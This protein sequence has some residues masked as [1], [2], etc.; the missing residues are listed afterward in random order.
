MQSLASVH[1]RLKGVDPRPLSRPE[2]C[3]LITDLERLRSRVDERLMA[4]KAA[5]DSL[6]DAGADSS[7]V[8]RS[9]GRRSERQ[10]K[11]DSVTARGLAEM[12]ALA[13]SLAEGRLNVE[14][15]AIVADAAEQLTPKIATELIGA[16]ES[17]PADLFARRA[18]EFVG[19]H[20]TAAQAEKQHRRQR[21][22]RAAWHK[23]HGDGTVEIHGR[24]DKKTGEDVLAAWKLRTDRLWH[25]D[26][27]RDGTPDQA[28]T[29]TQRRAD[30][31][32]GLITDPAPMGGPI[33]PRF[34]IHLVWN[35][36]E[37]HA[38]WLDGSV[39]P[40]SVLEEIGPQADVIAHIFDGDGQPLWQGR[41]KRLATVAQ[42]RSLIVASRGCATCGADIDRCQA[43][44]L[45]EWL[46]G[47]PTNVDNL[48]L[49]CHTCHGH[50]HRG[51]RT[52]RRTTPYRADPPPE[53]HQ[54]QA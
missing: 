27:G 49:L 47:G 28:R 46:E 29:H 8:G 10:A 39:V 51:Q 18:R 53:D 45:R 1:E 43:H 13:D 14:H 42:W 32:A 7:V 54:L 31:L 37:G 22:R 4:A 2:L 9:L 44:H 21:D 38:I 25:D 16:A 50:E 12:P 3:D 15:A 40:D 34:Q 35:L 17:M 41:S 5:L 11:R 23:V 26:G 30:A 52:R 6:G 20:T 19:K 33:H 36:A 48:E 24:L